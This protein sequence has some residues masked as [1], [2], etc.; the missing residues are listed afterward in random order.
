MET[1]IERGEKMSV[2]R[3][4][5]RVIAFLLMHI[6]P[7]GTMSHYYWLDCLAMEHG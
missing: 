1:E 6:L 5:G 2:G 7:Q 3:V 4:S